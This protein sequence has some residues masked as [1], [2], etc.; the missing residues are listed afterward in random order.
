M[1]GAGALPVCHLNPRYLVECTDKSTSDALPDVE[2][3]D[4]TAAHRID[5]GTFGCVAT[6]RFASR[7]ACRSMLNCTINKSETRPETTQLLTLVQLAKSFRHRMLCYLTVVR[8]R[9]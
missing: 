7:A 8:F 1:P 9:V 4:S 5:A 3:T 6:E 2:Q